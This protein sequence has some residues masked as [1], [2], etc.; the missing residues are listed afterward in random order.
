[1]EAARA[2][3]GQHPGDDPD[4]TTLAD[5][6]RTILAAGLPA[7]D[8]SPTPAMP[9]QGG[10]AAEPTGTGFANLTAW[11]RE[12]LPEV[13]VILARQIGPMARFLLKKVADKAEGLDHLGE[14]L[15]PHIPSDLGRVHFQQA[16]A[17][18]GKKLDATGTG[19]GAPGR[20]TV[21]GVNSTGAFATS[22]G[23]AAAASGRTA[24]TV[25][26]AFDQAYADALATK[27]TLLIGPIARV[28]AKRA[29]KQTNDKLEFVQLLASHIDNPGER[30]R[31]IA[32]SGGA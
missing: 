26:V 11:K 19:T 30:A 13:E 1:M 32:D 12:A 14:L 27:L 21:T 10:V 29:M 25:P 15:L 31:F 5:S 17:L 22:T 2:G 20:S 24:I 3:A 28:I 8:R 7:L 6:D 18:V 9:T 23:T 16:L 4:A